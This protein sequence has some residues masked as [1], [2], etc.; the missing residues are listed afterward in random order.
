MKIKRLRPRETEPVPRLLPFRDPAWTGRSYR[1][2]D[3]M[4]G[5]EMLVFMAQEVVEGVQEHARQKQDEVFGIVLGDYAVDQEIGQTFL[6]VQRHI[7]SELAKSHQDHV[8][9]DHEAWMEI[10]EKWETSCPDKLKVGWYHTHP[11]YGIFLSRKD[12]FI[13]EQFYRYPEYRY[14]IA[15][16]LDPLTEIDGTM[17]NGIFLWLDGRVTERT[18]Y[19]IFTCRRDGPMTEQ[20][21]QENGTNTGTPGR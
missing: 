11:G 12:L 9:V 13:Q 10:H 19:L 21:V 4:R 16:V 1:M 7:A 6:V 15:W 17:D 5:G 14:M 2:H 3:S 8:R 18:G 20:G